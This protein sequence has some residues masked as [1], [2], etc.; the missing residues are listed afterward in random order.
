MAEL[1]KVE[2]L[3]VEFPLEAGV[4][5]AVDHLSF[6]IN[7]G[8]AVGI[9]GESGSGKTVTA[10]AIIRLLAGGATIVEGSVWLRGQDLAALTEKKMQAIRGRRIAMIF[11]EPMTSLNPSYTVGEQV[12]E[13][14]RYNMG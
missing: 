7:E 13:V 3:T 9:V 10:L 11:Q 5:R 4:L 6:T 12:A 14:F 8:E 1:L 2:D